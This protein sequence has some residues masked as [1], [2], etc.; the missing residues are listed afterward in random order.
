MDETDMHVVVFLD[1]GKDPRFF[2]FADIV[3]I[4]LKSFD[5]Q[6]TY[7]IC[8]DSPR[9]KYPGIRVFDMED[10][11]KRLRLAYKI[12]SEIPAGSNPTPGKPASAKEE[13][14]S[15]KFQLNLLDIRR[16]YIGQPEYFKY[17]ADL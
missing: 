11:V 1:N 10:L 16:I 13:N 6:Y 7:I 14:V 15:A 5:K 3:C 9:T 4:G 8:K 17:D 2:K 12:E